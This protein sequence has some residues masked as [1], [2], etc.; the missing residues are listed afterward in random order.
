MNIKYVF[1]RIDQHFIE[2]DCECPKCDCKNEYDMS[3]ICI[4]IEFV[5]RQRLIRFPYNAI[6]NVQNV[7][8]EMNM[9]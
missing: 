9:T 3:G 7:I 5:F 1:R 8:V 2:C 6:V 4:K